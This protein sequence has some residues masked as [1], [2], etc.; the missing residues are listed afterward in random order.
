M[1]KILLNLLEILTAICGVSC[2]S[3][4]ALMFATN[5]PQAQFYYCIH[6]ATWGFACILLLSIVER[7]HMAHKDEV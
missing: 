7:E 2:I 6:T 3:C 1:P 5:A 4:L